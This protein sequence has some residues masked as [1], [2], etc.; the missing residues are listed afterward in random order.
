[1]AGP[2]QEMSALA[3]R[4][5]K[6]TTTGAPDFNTALGAFALCAGLSSFQFDH[7]IAEGQEFYEVDGG[8]NPC[9]SRKRPDIVKRTTFTLTLCTRDH[10]VDEIMGVGSPV[11][12]APAPTGKV[13]NVTQGCGGVT[14]PNGFALELWSE[15]WDCNAADEDPYIRSVLGRAYAVPAGFTK[16]NGVAKPVY[17]GF[18][19][20]NPNFGDGPFGDLDDLVGFTDWSYAEV[21]DDALPTCADPLAYI[22]LPSSAS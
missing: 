18:S 8:G 3:V 16:E 19:V 7:E 1:M 17:K 15:R 22:P 14:T 5:S 6:L 21:D 11:G 13:V 10:R 4:L 12:P 9:V 20:P 2:F